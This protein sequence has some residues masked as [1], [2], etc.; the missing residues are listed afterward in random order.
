MIDTTG[1]VAF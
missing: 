1:D